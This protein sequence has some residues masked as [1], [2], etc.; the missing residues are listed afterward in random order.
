MTNLSLTSTAWSESCPQ[1]THTMKRH[2]PIHNYTR[3]RES[4]LP[5]M[6]TC[7]F[8]GAIAHKLI[9]VLIDAAL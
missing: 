1:P 5:M 7:L 6:L 9:S 4:R 2:I 3:H 8:L